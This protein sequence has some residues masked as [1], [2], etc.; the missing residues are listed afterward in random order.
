MAYLID[1]KAISKQIKDIRSTKADGFM[2]YSYSAVF[3]DEP[4]NKQETNAI[5]NLLR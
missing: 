1:G 3:S 2:L 4:R 5:K